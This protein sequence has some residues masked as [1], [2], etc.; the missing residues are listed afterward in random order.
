MFNSVDTQLAY[1]FNHFMHR[2][3]ALDALIFQV[4]QN[5][6]FKGAVFLSIITF[7]WFKV[8]II[9]NA[10]KKRKF[11][12]VFIVAIVAISIARF[13]ALFSPFR[14]RPVHDPELHLQTPFSVNEWVLN[15]WSSFPSDHMALFFAI[16]LSIYF[17]HK[18]LGKGALLYTAIF[19]GIPRLLLGFHYLT[20][21]L[22]GMMIGLFS[23]WLGYTYMLHSKAMD[24]LIEFQEQKPA[25][26]FPLLVLFSCQ[27][28]EMFESAREFFPIFKWSIK[29][30]FLS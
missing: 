9:D 23:A 5:H 29:A 1:Y 4:A 17:L 6:L 13:M 24:K 28:Y 22:A 26:F 30:L 25:Y 2:H 7:A 12:M 3:Q 27:L 21:E 18:Q 20:D 8:D 19:I 15:H 16:S 14:Y 10:I 11:L